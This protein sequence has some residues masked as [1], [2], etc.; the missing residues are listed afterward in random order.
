[1]KDINDVFKE[2]EINLIAQHGNVEFDRSM[3]LLI[4]WLNK[5]VNSGY[6]SKDEARNYFN[7]ELNHRKIHK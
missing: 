2:A 1:M 6:M 3:E 7:N 4:N 5:A